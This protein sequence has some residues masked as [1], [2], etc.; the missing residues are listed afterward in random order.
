MIFISPSFLKDSFADIEFM[1][2]ICNALDL[3][4]M[5]S[6]ESAVVWNLFLLSCCF[7]D[8]P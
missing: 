1:V 8:S 3:V 2:G 6:D 7:Q 4:S 5:V